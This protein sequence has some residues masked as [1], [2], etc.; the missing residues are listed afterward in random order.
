MTTVKSLLH[1]NY[2]FY[3]NALRYSIFAPLFNFI[4]WVFSAFSNPIIISTIVGLNHPN[5]PILVSSVLIIFSNYFASQ[6]TFLQ[7]NVSK[8][9]GII[10]LGSVHRELEFGRALSDGEFPHII[11]YY[12]LGLIMLICLLYFRSITELPGIGIY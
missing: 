9:L 5:L 4:W 11:F 1:T 3:I 12:L 7:S 8:I 2:I 6:Q 10:I